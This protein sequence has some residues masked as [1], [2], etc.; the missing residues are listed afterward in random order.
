MA[1]IIIDE[2]EEKNKKK[3]FY[4]SLILHILLLVLAL[5]PLL[6]FPVPPPGQEGILVNLGTPDVG[7]GEENA[8]PAKAEPAPSKPEPAPTPPPPEPE[9]IPEPTPPEPEPIPE[10]PVEAPPKEV[11]TDDNSKEIAL[12]KEKERKKKEEDRLKKL[13]EDR[14]KKEKRDAERKKKAE[15][16]AR[17]KKA[18]EEARKK[19]AA[20]AEAKRKADE[21]RRKA[22]A[23]AAAKAKAEADARAEAA[24]LIGN[25][26][27]SGPGKGKT[28]T[29][30]NQGDPNGDPNSNILEGVSAGAGSSVGGGLRGRGILNK[31]G[32]KDDFNKPGKVVMKVCVN[33]SGRVISAT[34][35]QRGST[36]TDSQLVKLA[37]KNALSY[38]FSKGSIDKQC[39][40][41]TYTFKVR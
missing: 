19:A 39:G 11:I 4:T 18:Q 38:K 9:P 6:T 32:I 35:T 24:D 31:P 8:P 41:I 10:A 14:I 22:A 17:R 1:Q 27:G 12:Q 20:E 23:E 15:E 21:A 33:A 5:L 34:F 16:D 25:L 30:G 36:T 3:G 40:T 7:Q 37:K 26:G 29:S 13:E 28:G 2:I